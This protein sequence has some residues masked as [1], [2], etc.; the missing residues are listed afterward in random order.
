M[1]GCRERSPGRQLTRVNTL[2]S[3]PALWRTGVVFRAN[4]AQAACKT[5]RGCATLKA[6]QVRSAFYFLVFYLGP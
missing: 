1:S 3:A 2:W 6:M 5:T 4:F